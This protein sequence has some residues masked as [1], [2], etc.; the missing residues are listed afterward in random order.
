MKKVVVLTGAGISAESGIKT[1]RDSDGLWE[2]YRVEEVAT[3]D[4]WLKDSDL[5]RRFYNQRRKDVMEALPNDGHNA[6]LA[7]EKNFDVRIITQNIDDLH[8]RAGSKNVLHLHGE[9]K[10]LV[11]ETDS[12]YIV[13]MQSWEQTKDMVDAHG[14]MLRPFIVWFG[15]AVPNIV[16]AIELCEQADIM[17][18]IGTSLNVYPA[19]G[20]LSYAKS[21]CVKYLVDP[22]EP[23]AS[24]KGIHFIKEK[25]STGVKK[26]VDEIIERYTE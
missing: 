17:I 1:F 12:S 16:P 24:L 7:L 18:V 2:N 8:E 5:V 26:A 23:N 9:A 22:K 3:Y 15:E 11:S 25:A 14:R 20:L 6:L 21:S 10:K 4:A 19:A 13:E